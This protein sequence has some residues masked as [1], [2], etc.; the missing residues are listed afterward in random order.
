MYF[1]SRVG[2]EVVTVEIK[3]NRFVI[4]FRDPRH[5]DEAVAQHANSR[6]WSVQLGDV[7]LQ[8]PSLQLSRAALPQRPTLATAPRA[9]GGPLTSGGLGGASLLVSSG[10]RV[11]G[12]VPRRQGPTRRAGEAEV[13]SRGVIDPV[14]GKKKP[15]GQKKDNEEDPINP[16][17]ERDLSTSVSFPQGPPLS[18]RSTA[19]TASAATAPLPDQSSPHSDALNELLATHG[20]ATT[21]SAPRVFSS[22]GNDD[23][24]V[25]PTRRL[26]L[27]PSAAPM[28][29]ATAPTEAKAMDTSD[30]P[31]DPYQRYAQLVSNLSK[32]PT[33]ELLRVADGLKQLAEAK[34]SGVY[35][36]TCALLDLDQPMAVLA[37]TVVDRLVGFVRIDEAL[38]VFDAEEKDVAVRESSRAATLRADVTHVKEVM[39]RAAEKARQA[40]LA[41]AKAAPKS[42]EE[43][44]TGLHLL[45]DVRDACSNKCIGWRRHHP[46]ASCICGAS[47]TWSSS[48]KLLDIKGESKPV[49]IFEGTTFKNKSLA[50][51]KF[52][53]RPLGGGSGED[54]VAL[55]K[56][57]AVAAG[58]ETIA[59]FFDEAGG[60][61]QAQLAGPP[62]IPSDDVAAPADQAIT[63]ALATTR[64]GR[65]NTN[66]F[67]RVPPRVYGTRSGSKK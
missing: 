52:R 10:Q 42:V 24:L 2:G 30:A 19:S 47:D 53:L 43:V 4:T 67:L 35:V 44:V 31:L 45:F 49:L 51:I 12:E 60:V 39:A 26:S 66:A 18:S 15:G 50:Q 63:N 11:V 25:A 1:G 54:A 32:M 29:A 8:P 55:L 58:L 14:G 5:A 21:P 61:S 64:L 62:A 22:E 6:D 16:V 48:L 40:E 46:S 34:K 57:A 36:R 27:T 38:R 41:S 37:A 28:A 65:S 33:A 7:P 3:E 56:K 9:L 59:S 17:P 20:G 13:D 23:T